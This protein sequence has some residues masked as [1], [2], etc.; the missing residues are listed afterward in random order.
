MNIIDGKKKA[1]IVFALREQAAG[2]RES[3][4][5]TIRHNS[6]R[7]PGSPDV[8][9]AIAAELESRAAACEAL[10]A[11]IEAANHIVLGEP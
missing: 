10:A 1:L 3:I 11:D 6:V 2:D 4:P 8:V 9:N 7:R 5:E